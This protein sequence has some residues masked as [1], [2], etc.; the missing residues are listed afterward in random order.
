MPPSDP[1]PRLVLLCGGENTRLR[2]LR[3]TVYKPFLDIED[4]T[5]VAQQVE[6]ARREGLEEVVVVTDAE[7]GLVTRLIREIRA[8]VPGVELAEATVAGS[9]EE[10]IVAVA[11]HD[12]ALVAHGDTHAWFSWRDLID[13]ATQQAT[14]SA[15]LVAPYRLPFGVVHVAEDGR[16]TTFEEKPETGYLVNLG[17][18][19]LGPRALEM[20][21]SGT[22]LVDVLRTLSADGDVATLRAGKATFLT[23]DGPEDVIAAQAHIRKLGWD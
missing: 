21:G 18:M 23:L 19:L 15:I 17:H 4:S 20:L 5:F 16:A 9:V 2:S 7:D 1:A 13:A 8:S 6:R 14:D 11:P 3:H 12:R 10:K 22:S